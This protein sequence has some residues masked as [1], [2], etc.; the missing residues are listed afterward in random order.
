MKKFGQYNLIL[1]NKT[2]TIYA[3]QHSETSIFIDNI[4]PTFSTK[5]LQTLFPTSATISKKNTTAHVEF[6]TI[7]DKESALQSS[8]L[9]IDLG[10]D[11]GVNKWIRE[12]EQATP[13]LEYLDSLVKKELT[14]WDEMMEEKRQRIKQL[15]GVP[16]E[17]GFIMV[18]SKNKKTEAKQGKK[19]KELV[20]FYKF[21]MKETKIN[22]LNE[23]RARFEQDK[24]RIELLKTQ[25]K[26]KPY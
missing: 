1:I 24:K 10:T 22:Q 23:L 17:D 11:F 9:E 21:Q 19:K 12:L 3:K 13:S 26:F 14:E 2:Y 5:H 25:R 7:E 16:D 4:P 15:K 20:D 6:N 18:T 8:E